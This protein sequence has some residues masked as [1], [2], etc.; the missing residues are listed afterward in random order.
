MYIY[1]YWYKILRFI[2]IIQ[3]IFVT[4][5]LASNIHLN[6]CSL[7]FYALRVHLNDF[8]KRVHT[9]LRILFVVVENFIFDVTEVS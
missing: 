3:S 7:I 9:V 2:S 8:S 4:K 1:S 6:S 5:I